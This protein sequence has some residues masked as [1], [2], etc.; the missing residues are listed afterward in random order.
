MGP[1]P[2]WPRVSG[3][4]SATTSR[5][6]ILWNSK[7]FKIKIHFSTIFPICTNRYIHIAWYKVMYLYIGNT[8]QCKNIECHPINSL[9]FIAYILHVSA[10][11]TTEISVN[12]PHSIASIRT[13]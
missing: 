1:L 5:M 9:K 11:V 6:Y 13:T 12:V 3:G 4:A 8:K 2:K 10:R 7:V